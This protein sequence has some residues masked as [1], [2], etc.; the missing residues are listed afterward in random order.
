MSFYKNV[1]PLPQTENKREYGQESLALA[2]VFFMM[3]TCGVYFLTI[4]WAVGIMLS[5]NESIINIHPWAG[6]HDGSLGEGTCHQ[7]GLMTSVQF[8]VTQVKV[9]ES[10][11]LQVVPWPLHA[12]CHMCR[13]TQRH[14]EEKEREAER[15]RHREG[16]KGRR[17]NVKNKIVIHRAQE[18]T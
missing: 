16:A 3:T 14:I 4:L 17:S 6:M 9:R 12:C 2:I 15:E 10:Q 5:G 18:M 1:K 8:P 11:I 13:N 7:A